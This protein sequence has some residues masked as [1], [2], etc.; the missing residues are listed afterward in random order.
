MIC[1]QT[2]ALTPLDAEYAKKDYLLIHYN[3][4][5]EQRGVKDASGL[6]IGQAGSQNGLQAHLPVVVL[7][8]VERGT[9]RGE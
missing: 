6:R 8:V 5:T 9:D 1:V 3:D 7:E 4:N 2:Y